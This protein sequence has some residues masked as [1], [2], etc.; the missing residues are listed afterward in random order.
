MKT[1]LS[2]FIILVILSCYVKHTEAQQNVL[3][4]GG[5]AK[6]GTGTVSYSL[7]QLAFLTLSGTEATLSEGAQQPYEILFNGLND[8]GFSLE[9]LAHPNPSDD[10]VRLKI[11][12]PEIK[13][14]SYRLLN[15]NGLI[16]GESVIKEKETII[17]LSEL[18]PGAYFLLV[19]ENEVAVS[20]YKIIKK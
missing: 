2:F 12:N 6:G 13:N 3:T 8:P 10:F 11:E 5:E 17:P 7:G 9:C 15:L 19:C 20:S 4:A 14:L 16:L 18:S 1:R